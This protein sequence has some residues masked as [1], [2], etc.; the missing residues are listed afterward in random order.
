MKSLANSTLLTL[1][2]TG[3]VSL[4]LKSESKMEGNAYVD[5]HT[6]QEPAGEIRGQLVLAAPSSAAKTTVIVALFLAI[7]VFA[8]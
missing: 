1:A 8:A 7:A 6:T 3:L 4:W 5:I 2:S